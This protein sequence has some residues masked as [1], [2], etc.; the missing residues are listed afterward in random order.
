MIGTF[1]DASVFNHG[2]FY[3]TIVYGGDSRLVVYAYIYTSIYT[4]ISEPNAT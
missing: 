1:R 3:T 2:L 4:G